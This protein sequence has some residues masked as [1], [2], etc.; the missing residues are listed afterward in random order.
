MNVNAS[1]KTIA[2]Q[3]MD[4]VMIFSRT[5]GMTRTEIWLNEKS[6]KQLLAMVYVIPILVDLVAKKIVKKITSDD[7][8]TVKINRFLRM[9]M[10]MQLENQP[11][12]VLTKDIVVDTR[13]QMF[14]IQILLL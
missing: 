11:I 2:R 5:N 12:H 6:W 13:H 14:Y 10:S 7:D 9:H 1:R 4:V 8:T 3:T